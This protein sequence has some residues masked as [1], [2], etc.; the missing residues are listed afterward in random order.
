MR[1]DVVTEVIVDYGDFVENFATV[2]EAKDYINSNL[3]ELDWPVAVWLEDSSGRKK[4]DY[5]L[6]DDGAGGVELIEGDTIQ[7]GS[8]YRPI[9]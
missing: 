8:Y 4:W 7:S 1:R 2:L 9:H 5:R 3:D 6:V